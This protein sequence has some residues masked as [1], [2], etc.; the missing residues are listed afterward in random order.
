MTY[1]TL[2]ENV[3]LS[4]VCSHFKASYK[5]LLFFPEYFQSITTANMSPEE[6][7][8]ISKFPERHMALLSR[9][10]KMPGRKTK[11]FCKRNDIQ[12]NSAVNSKTKNRI[13]NSFKIKSVSKSREVIFTDEDLKSLLM[14]S[15]F[16]LEELE[17]PNC[18]FVTDRG[19][20]LLSKFRNL[21]NLKLQYLRIPEEVFVS[22]IINCKF[23]QSISITSCQRLTEQ[24]LRRLLNES[25][26][27]VSIELI[28]SKN[29]FNE[30]NCHLFSS[31]KMLEKIKLAGNGLSFETICVI[32]EAAKSLKRLELD[33]SECSFIE[34]LR[35]R[36]SNRP[37][38]T[39]N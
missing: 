21:R 8:Y 1:L 14:M 34:G 6:L 25:F 27:L 36:F 33:G 31:P 4:A 22:I 3:K 19:F 5:F 12:I 23:L 20:T 16:S 9:M 10:M 13:V 24:S 38:L 37:S 28:N 17:L 18:P 7:L 26:W 35:V 2:K 15:E 11:E 30:L 29:L 32:V 39:I